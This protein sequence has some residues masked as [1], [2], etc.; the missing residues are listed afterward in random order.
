M[1]SAPE[2]LKLVRT[3]AKLE[4]RMAPHVN[5][6]QQAQTRCENGTGKD[7]GDGGTQV[8]WKKLCVVGLCV[9][10]LCVCVKHLY[11]R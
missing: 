11:R 8:V 2:I 5:F 6:F 10:E 9:K 3:D 4:G 7:I 1:L